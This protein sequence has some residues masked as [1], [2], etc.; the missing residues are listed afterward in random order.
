MGRFTR[1]IFFIFLLLSSAAFAQSVKGELFR[2]PPRPAPPPPQP[3]LVDGAPIREATVDIVLSGVAA[4]TAID[5]TLG[6]S[7]NVPREATVNLPIAAGQ[8]MARFALDFNG[9]LRYAMAV[10]K[11]R[12]REVFEAIERRRVDPALLEKTEGENFRLRV[13]PIMPQGTRKARFELI[14][15][16]AG[17]LVRIAPPSDALRTLDHFA[18]KLHIS[19]DTLPEVRLGGRPLHVQAE[20]GGFLVILDDHQWSNAMPIEVRRHVKPVAVAI[21]ASGKDHWLVADVPVPVMSGARRIAPVIGLLWDSSTS[22]SK[23][24][25]DIEMAELDSYF[26]AMGN[27]EVHLQRLRDHAEPIQRFTVTHGDWTE[28]RDTLRKNAV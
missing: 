11:S 8:Q 13:F 5:L 2:I 25:A 16:A 3:Q 21:D 12:G 7:S 15:A 22:H 26:K 24:A 14:E 10:E 19:G 20:P 1:Q 6:N 17:E 18:A 28:L 23:E 4:T 27:G 9:H